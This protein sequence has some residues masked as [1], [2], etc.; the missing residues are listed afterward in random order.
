M[1]SSHRALVTSMIVLFAAI[2]YFSG[3]YSPTGLMAYFLSTLCFFSPSIIMSTRNRELTGDF[4]EINIL[5][6]WSLLS[7]LILLLLVFFWKQLS[8]NNITPNH[9]RPKNSQIA[10][11]MA[12]S[13]MAMS[14]F[15][16]PLLFV[17]LFIHQPASNSLLSSDF[18]GFLSNLGVM[19][20][21]SVMGSIIFWKRY[22]PWA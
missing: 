3:D 10:L 18:V 14:T 17:S 16:S 7:G 19:W 6:C 4:L 22:R 9:N 11:R 5:L 21:L 15:L 12:F 8:V 20:P 1:S 2:A 13:A